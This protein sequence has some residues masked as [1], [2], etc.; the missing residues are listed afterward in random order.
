MPVLVF[1][2]DDPDNIVKAITG[3]NIGTV[4]TG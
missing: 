1:S 4:V 3:E 2:L